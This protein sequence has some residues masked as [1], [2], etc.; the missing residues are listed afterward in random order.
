MPSGRVATGVAGKRKNDP[1]WV[2]PERDDVMAERTILRRIPAEAAPLIV[3]R[4]SFGPS[5]FDGDAMTAEAV[6]TAYADVARRDARGGFIERLDPA[7]LDTASLGGAPLLDGH[8]QGGA[9][10]V[11]GVVQS[12]RHEPGR[13]V[14]V[15]RLSTADDAA[16]A[17]TRIREGTLRGVSVGYPVANWRE[18]VEGGQRIRT[19][20]SWAVFEVSAVPVAADPA[21]SFRSRTME[22]DDVQTVERPEAEPTVTETRAAIRGIARAVGG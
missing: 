15:L 3:R 4:G 16:P 7:G 11:I 5:T 14:A 21:A 8:R 6:I 10:D 12:L 17:V 19:A 2:R 1:T 20:T 9:R 18:S 13:L 22:E